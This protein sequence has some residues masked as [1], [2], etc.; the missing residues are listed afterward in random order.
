MGFCKCISIFFTL[1]SCKCKKIHLHASIV[2]VNV[3]KIHVNVND[4]HLCGLMRSIYD[5]IHLHAQHIYFL[6][7]IHKHDRGKTTHQF[8]VNN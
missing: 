6:M 2:I 3:K 1:L 4:L 7:S 8:R 5:Y